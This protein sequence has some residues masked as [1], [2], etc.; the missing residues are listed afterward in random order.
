MMDKLDHEK[1][2][3]YTLGKRI[4]AEESCVQWRNLILEIKCKDLEMAIH[5]A[6]SIRQA[7]SITCDA[8]Y[9]RCTR[10]PCITCI[11]R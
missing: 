7:K 6:Q 11:T 10:F 5:L 4:K 8:L 2:N 1:E 3:K 9:A